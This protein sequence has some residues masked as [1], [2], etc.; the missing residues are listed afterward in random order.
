[1]PFCHGSARVA[2][3]AIQLIALLL[4]QGYFLTPAFQKM[5]KSSAG[6]KCFGNHRLCGCP[7]ERI[8]NKTCCCFRAL[9]SC[10]MQGDGNGSSSDTAADNGGAVVQNSPCGL[11]TDSGMLSLDKLKF[12]AAAP[13]PAKSA[14]A[15]PCR[16]PPFS[17]KLEDRLLEPPDPPPHIVIPV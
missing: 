2:C 4:L 15:A 13:A 16:F 14:A 6:G 11:F 1:M 7:P 5:V 10:C 17:E 8:A 9:H 12:L 3:V